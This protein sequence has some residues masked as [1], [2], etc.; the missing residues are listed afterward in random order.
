MCIFGKMETLE[1]L[2]VRRK[3]ELYEQTNRRRDDT[4]VP[5]SWME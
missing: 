1:V 3:G 2:M 5:R 4:V